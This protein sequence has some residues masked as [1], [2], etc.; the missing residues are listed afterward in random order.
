VAAVFVAILLNGLVNFIGISAGYFFNVYAQNGTPGAYL[1]SFTALAQL[2]DLYI[3]TL[4][5]ALFGLLA[6]LV[7]SYKGLNAKGGPKGVG[8]AVN[9]SVVITF[10]L[11]FVV[12]FVIT[13]LYF[14]VIP[15]K[16]S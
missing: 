8:D 12:N 6:A 14:A 5:A 3:G 4:K 11:L 1:S 16:G 13:T 9:Q 2:P 10:M 15:Q 7:A